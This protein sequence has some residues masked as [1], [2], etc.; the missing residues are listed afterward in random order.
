MVVG[1]IVYNLAPVSLFRGEGSKYYQSNHF[2]NTSELICLIPRRA[3][4]ERGCSGCKEAAYVGLDLS[5]SHCVARIFRLSLRLSLSLNPLALTLK[6]SQ[7]LAG[8]ERSDTPG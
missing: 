7:Q 2:I 3:I 1:K 5:A 4:K 6:G 8:V